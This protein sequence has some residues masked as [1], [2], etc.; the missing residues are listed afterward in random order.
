MLE[1]EETT[2]TTAQT[3]QMRNKK[4]ARCPACYCG[5]SRR[6]KNGYCDHVQLLIEKT[7]IVRPMS[8]L[9]N[10]QIEHLFKQC[11]KTK[12]S[13][14]IRT[15]I[16]TLVDNFAEN[17]GECDEFSYWTNLDNLYDDIDVK[18]R[19]VINK[20]A[21]YD[22]DVM[23]V[24]P[25]TEVSNVASSSMSIHV[26]DSQSSTKRVIL[27]V[28]RGRKRYTT[29]CLFVWDRLND[30]TVVSLKDYLIEECEWGK[31]SVFEIMYTDP[32]TQSTLLVI[33]K[34]VV[35]FLFKY[36]KSATKPEIIIDFN[37]E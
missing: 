31:E 24:A 34:R 35:E 32:E 18:L 29:I 30:E 20:A 10:R 22:L 33:T 17:L 11:I 15:I 37:C 28:E 7:G 21:G 5:R 19:D 3:K 6:N 8:G 23:E 14:A 1:S 25:A 4:S 12:R 13:G 27:R 16:I 2:K 36:I 9:R 26:S